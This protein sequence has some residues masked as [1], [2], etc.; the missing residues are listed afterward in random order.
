MLPFVLRTLLRRTQVL[1]WYVARFVA[2]TL[3]L[4]YLYSTFIVANMDIKGKFYWTIFPL[5]EPILCATTTASVSGQ[6]FEIHTLTIAER[7][8][9]QRINDTKRHHENT[10]Y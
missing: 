9:F 5:A 3:N 8:T 10:K 6:F 4:L 2:Q 1:S 7:K